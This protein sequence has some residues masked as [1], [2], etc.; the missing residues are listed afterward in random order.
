MTGEYPMTSETKRIRIEPES[1]LARLLGEADN[2]P[3]LL[4][5]DGELYRLTKEKEETNWAGYNPDQVRAALRKSAGALRGVD[6]D[7]LLTDISL[8]R[9]QNSAGRPA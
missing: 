8:A 1:E 9:E 2:M 6:R 4:E 7:Q 3:L 5:K